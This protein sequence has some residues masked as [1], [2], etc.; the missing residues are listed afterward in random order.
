MTK[1]E[2]HHRIATLADELQEMHDLIS[3]GLPTDPEGFPQPENNDLHDALRTIDKAIIV[4]SRLA[5]RIAR[6]T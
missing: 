4:L 2:I 6:T 1:D 5:F 3:D